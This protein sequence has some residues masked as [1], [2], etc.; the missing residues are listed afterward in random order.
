MTRFKTWGKSVVWV[1]GNCSSVTRSTPERNLPKSALGAHHMM[2]HDV[3]HASG[4]QRQTARRDF[5]RPSAANCEAVSK[6]KEKTK[7][8][9]IVVVT[10][11]AG[12]LGTEIV[13]Q[14]LLSRKYK[15]R[16]T[17]RS[18]AIERANERWTHP[19]RHALR[20]LAGADERLELVQANLLDDGSFE[21][22]LAGAKYVFHTASP[23]VTDGITNPQ[24]QLIDP[25]VGGTR[26]VMR[27]AVSAGVQRVVVT[28][29][30][31]AIMGCLGE[32]EGGV[33]DEDDWNQ[34]SK[35]TS[36]NG[37]D[38]YRLS[39]NLAEQAA[40]DISKETGLEM[41]AI[42]PSFIIGPPR[43]APRIE[44]Y[45]IGAGESLSYMRAFLDGGAP[46][47]GDSPVA[48][49]RDVARAHILAAETPEAA[50]RRFL[51]SSPSALRMAEIS[52]LLSAMYPDLHILD[53][54]E[55]GAAPVRE[56]FRSKNTQSILGLR[57]R[58]HKDSVLDMAACLLKLHTVYTPY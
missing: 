50:G 18:L 41:A 27:S 42:N 5:E 21:K 28:S 32:K 56:V 34:S 47:R 7:D 17:L 25:A 54:G 37:L 40:W 31:G 48:D 44:S 13:A 35:L 57:L 24:A 15:V 58:P 52:R 36:G 45:R 43:I 12:Y 29:S 16:G 8:L 33:S 9:P 26:N 53:L 55:P 20:S 30:V 1:K 19:R 6:K 38:L 11:A 3:L 49:I 2:H 10:G 22:C 4:L 39:K 23:F 51:I 46:R 14:L